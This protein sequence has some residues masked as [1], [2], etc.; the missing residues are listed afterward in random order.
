MMFGERNFNRFGTWQNWD[1]NNGYINGWDWDTIRWSYGPPAPDR[2]DTSFYDRRF[3][4]SHPL[5]FNAAMSDGSVKAI[6]YPIDLTVFQ[7]LTDRND[8]KSPQL[9]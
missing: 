7:N 8:G 4:S 5:V 6:P 2:K 3:G 9:P 1:E